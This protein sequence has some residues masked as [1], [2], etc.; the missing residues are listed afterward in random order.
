MGLLNAMDCSIAGLLVGGPAGAI[1]G[2]IGGL[3][4]GGGAP[5]LALTCAGLTSAIAQNENSV[6]AGTGSVQQLSSLVNAYH[7]LLGLNSGQQQQMLMDMQQQNMQNLMFQ[8]QVNQQSQ[9]F[10]TLTN[11]QKAMHD[12]IMAMLNNAK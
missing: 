10:S 11:A 8:Q 2:G 6:R 9:R 4:G 3:I 5:N 1:M 7:G 12:A